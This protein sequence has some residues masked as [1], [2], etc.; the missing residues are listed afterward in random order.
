M[1]KTFFGDVI[2]T[3]RNLQTYRKI[4]SPS[5]GFKME[6]EISLKLPEFSTGL[7]VAMSED[8]FFKFPGNFPVSP[9]HSSDT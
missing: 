4:A 8:A 7:Q 2:L 9:T 5:S 1:N 6:A 3:N